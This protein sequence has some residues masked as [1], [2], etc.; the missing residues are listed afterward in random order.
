MPY[1]HQPRPGEPTYYATDPTSE[2]MIQL[3]GSAPTYQGV[4]LTEQQ[5]RRLMETY[6]LD[7]DFH[8]K[9]EIEHQA[10]LDAKYER[11]TAEYNADIAS[12]TPQYLLD[13]KWIG[14]RPKRR[15]ASGMMT[16]A[17]DTLT[18]YRLAS[19]D[20]LRIMGFL[21]EYLQPGEDPVGLIQQS[22]AALGFDVECSI[23]P[24]DDWLAEQE[25][26]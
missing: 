9:V 17:G 1:A 23:E 10:E 6:G 13:R 14:G 15:K 2:A 24:Y 4:A 3:F 8:K 18:A 25:I 22:L 21:A 19:Q 20:G 11:D 7:P 5:H 12:G 16:E 26:D